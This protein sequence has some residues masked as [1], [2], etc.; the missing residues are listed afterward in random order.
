MFGV[1]K[2]AL[3]H[4]DHAPKPVERLFVSIIFLGFYGCLLPLTILSVIGYFVYEY[5]FGMRNIN[6]WLNLIPLALIFTHFIGS[7]L[8][9][10]LFRKRK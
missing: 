2:A 6:Y 10:S 1:A 5:F 9:I 4:R 7:A 8:L 3:N